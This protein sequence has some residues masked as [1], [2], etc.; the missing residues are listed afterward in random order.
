M[1]ILAVLTWN[2]GGGLA[3]LVALTVYARWLVT[4]ADARQSAVG[5]AVDFVP[6]TSEIAAMEHAL[7]ELR[8]TYERRTT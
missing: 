5:F 3:V 4:T 8:D 1:T 2:V 6:F 7:P